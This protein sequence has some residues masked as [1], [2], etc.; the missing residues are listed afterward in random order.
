MQNNQPI[1]S[2]IG[3]V[4]HMIG[5]RFIEKRLAMNERTNHFTEDV[6]RKACQ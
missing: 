3:Q 6:C 2:L 4:L 1:F 5:S